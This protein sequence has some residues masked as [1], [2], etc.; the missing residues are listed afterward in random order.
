MNNKAVIFYGA[1]DRYNFGD[2]L[3]PIVLEEYFK[4][5]DLDKRYRFEFAY[6]AESD[7][8]NYGCKKTVAINGLLTKDNKESVLIV[9]G[10]EVLGARLGTLFTHVQDS[11]LAVKL[12]KFVNRWAPPLVSK[13]AQMFYPCRWEYPYVPG[14]D[15]FSGKIIFNTVGGRSPSSQLKRLKESVF[16]SA[17]DERTHSF[18]VENKIQAEMVPDSVLMISDLFSVDTLEDKVRTGLVDNLKHKKYIIIQVCPYKKPCEEDE[19]A[20][21]ILRFTSQYPDYKVVLLPI[22]YASG[23]DDV[24]FLRNLQEKIPDCT[25]LLYELTVW[26]ILYVI[27]NASAFYGTSLHGVITAMSYNVPYFSINSEI[28]KISSFLSTWSIAPLNKPIPYNSIVENFRMTQSI[29]YEQLSINTKDKIKLIK[30][31]VDKMIAEFA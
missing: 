27:A 22:G 29:D 6:I 20:E 14:N 1:F 7:L 8:T 18:F 26:E 12:L 11:L 25:E 16:I 5:Y 9:V 23:H 10:G 13:I 15:F 28:K 30:N 21:E 2:N 24:I 17:R 31:S 3:M 19:L 4:R